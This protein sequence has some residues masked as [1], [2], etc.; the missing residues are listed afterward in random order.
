MKKTAIT[1]LISVIF[2]GI[3]LSQTVTQTIKGSVFDKTTHL[4]LI[5][6]TIM[7]QNTSPIIGTTADMEGKFSL[8]NVPVGRQNIQVN[9][10]GYESYI[11]SEIIVGTGKQVI[12][13]IGLQEKYIALSQV[14]VRISKDAPI[15]SMATVSSRQFAVEETQRYAGGLDDP[16]RLAT[17]FAGVAN[18]SVSSNG[19]SVRGNNP[20]GLLW[21]VEG[22]EIP[23]PNHFANLTVVGGGLLTALSSNMMGNS[24]FYTG[25]FPSEYGNATSGVFDIKLKTGNS[26]KREYTF[27]AGVIG[28]DFATEGPF[29]K[30]KEA[31]YLLN[32]RYSTMAL[33]SSIL[34]DNTGVLKYQDFSYKVNLPTKKA[35]TFSLWGL[36]AFDKQEM[37]ALDSAKWESNFDRDNSQ[38]SL[39]M[40]ALGLAHKIRLNSSTFLNSTLSAS[41][42]GLLHK[43]QRLDYTLEP[44][45]QSKADKNTWRYT[46]QST[47]SHRFGKRHNNRTG[48]YISR[49]GYNINAEE[50]IAEG[51]L[52]VLIA[53][54]K[55]QSN[56]LQFYSQ[57]KI[58]LSPK[59][60]LNAGIHTQ[61]FMLNKNHS[62]EPRAALKYQLN[63]KQSLAIAYGLHSR[64]ESLSVY[65]V[66]KGGKQPNRD[67]KLMKSEHYVLSYNAKISEN[68]RLCIE[69]Y[70]Q[71][72]RNVPVSPNSYVSTINI[73]NDV[74]FDEALVSSGTGRNI[75]VDLTLERFLNKGFYYLF[76]ASIFDS[77]YTGTDGIERN[78]RFNKNYVFNALM[79]KEWQVGR[80][81]NNLLSA[82]IRL[83][84]MGGNR[85]ESIDFQNSLNNK[86]VEY[87]ETGGNLSFTKRFP[88]MPIFSFTLSYRKNKPN[89]STVWSLQI[90]NATGTK[91]FST[92]H[93]NIKTGAIDT[94]YD[95]IVIPNIS[96]RIE[97]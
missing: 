19:I 94:K 80:Q 88:D 49:L 40:Y 76:T 91:Q 55:G 15:N 8:E 46:F 68:L 33:I 41:G 23:N 63:Q 16:A 93:Y 29:V 53:K 83:N 27:Q 90:M 72:L 26:S 7:V 32:Y 12:L 77:K 20:S 18:P 4:P 35:G 69:P 52:P 6:A 89:Y 44:K 11:A 66:D 85:K 42:N 22:V 73:E 64:L 57:S 2:C 30:G 48:I 79:G 37:V 96:Y 9:M 61:Y 78:T 38:T 71:R 50:S 95:G 43:E 58:Q 51:T 39:H 60:T 97:F 47:I 13:N 31:S 45:P 5:G 24:D 84:Y 74:F 25:A 54:E 3:S 21:R 17:S 36:T 86:K 70:Y 62:I 65:F 81:K 34:P 28:I 92:D 14:I 10:L 67:L 1:T 59:L 87:A 75:G 82:N 56:L